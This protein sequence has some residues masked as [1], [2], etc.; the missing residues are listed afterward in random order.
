MR[1]SWRILS[2]ASCEGA[3][4]TCISRDDNW[5][6]RDERSRSSASMV[7]R[8]DL[9]SSKIE[10]SFDCSSSLN[11][12]LV[13]EISPIS[14]SY[15]FRSDMYSANLAPAPD[16]GGGFIP[17]PD[18]GASIASIL[19]LQPSLSLPTSN[20]SSRNRSAS[21]TRIM[22]C[23][24]HA[25]SRSPNP[26]SALRSW[27]AEASRPARSARSWSSTDSSLRAVAASRSRAS[28]AR[29]PS[30]SASSSCAFFNSF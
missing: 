20:N 29:R 30:D 11:A 19:S 24:S 23:A 8:S 9:R 4:A 16:D 21:C 1:S 28:V 12:L 14:A 17:P 6:D 25:A 5:L 27:V 15:A 18:A 7:V 26:S 22:R 2:T 3:L 13:I 10:S